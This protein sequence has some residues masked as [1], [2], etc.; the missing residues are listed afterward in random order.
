[1]YL[2][3][4]DLCIME[5]WLSCVI[6]GI[7]MT[8]RQMQLISLSTGSFPS[9]NNIYW[10]ESDVLASNSIDAIFDRHRTYLL[11]RLP[12]ASKHPTASVVHFRV[13]QSRLRGCFWS[14]A[15]SFVG[16]KWRECNTGWLNE[17][18]KQNC[19]DCVMI[20]SI[21]HVLKYW[22]C[23]W[24]SQAVTVCFITLSLK[25]ETASS[26][27]V[28]VLFISSR[29]RNT[30]KKIHFMRTSWKLQVELVSNLFVLQT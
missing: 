5:L 23:L 11:C 14:R 22:C 2:G 24:C 6:P 12:L 16:R 21:H 18:C 15:P 29:V 1:M 17:G 8:Q 30:Q 10:L 9:Q 7:R 28:S 13:L 4:L 3:E 27:H 26:C 19:Y 25:K 20:P